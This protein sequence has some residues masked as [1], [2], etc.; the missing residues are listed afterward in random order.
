[1]KGSWQYEQEVHKIEAD[2]KVLLNTDNKANYALFVP[3]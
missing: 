2:N 3:V 1:V